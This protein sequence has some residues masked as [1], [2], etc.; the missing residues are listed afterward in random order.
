M[1]YISKKL[2]CIKINYKFLTLTKVDFFRFPDMRTVTNSYVL[3][4]AAA[5]L[6]FAFTI[7]IVAYTRVVGSWML[8]DVVCKIIPYTQVIMTFSLIST[9]IRKVFKK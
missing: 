2:A 5:D 9:S 8:G 1:T 7:P 4:L 6:L 3:N